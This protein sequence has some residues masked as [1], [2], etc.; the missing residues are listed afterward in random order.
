MG[1][2]RQIEDTI[3][4]TL[5][6]F[7][8]VKVIPRGLPYFVDSLLRGSVRFA[9]RIG[10]NIAMVKPDNTFRLASDISVSSRQ[11]FL[12]QP[13][14]WVTIDSLISL[15]PEK[16]LQQVSDI[17][18]NQVV[19]VDPTGR[20]YTAM[21][22][23]V[24]LYATPLEVAIDA[25]AGATTVSVRTHFPLVNGDVFAYLATSG[26]IQS[27]TEIKV[28]VSIIGGTTSDPYYNQLYQLQLSA[29]IGRQLLTNEIV[30]IRAYPAYFSQPIVVPN[31]IL[32]TEPLGPFLLDH[33]SGN[34]L[35]GSP[36][37]ETFAIKTLNKA[38]A[39]LAGTNYSY[40][41]VENNHLIMDRP[42][43]AHVP[44]FW[45]LAEGTMRFTPNRVVMR[46]NEDG[47][48]AVG[49]KCIPALD[50]NHSWRISIKSNENCTI[51]FIFYPNAPQEFTLTA[52][53]SLTTT[54]SI[55][56]NTDPIDRLEININADSS[57]GEIQISDWTPIQSNVDKVQYTLLIEATG[58]ATYLSSGL[59]LK[60]FFL[61]SDLL[62]TRYDQGSNY[63]G[64]KVYF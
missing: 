22:D 36:F 10:S 55:P 24:L 54:I 53:G 7:S 62:K 44:L 38:G 45:D 33:L 9:K 50:G 34:L 15:G 3:N 2:I 4:A 46:V 27:F 30:Y 42:V 1:R 32:S 31:S 25:P 17:I 37:V 20:S 51:R 48:F 64:G 26:F 49:Y 43:A 56:A 21:D 18:D 40:Q 58:I 52:G 35:E 5:S 60:P 29:P 14:E 6:A 39:F 11:V 12:A 16:E 63:D 59:I 13:S 57:Q 61:T 23:R 8:H 28:S 47:K 41:T 19:L